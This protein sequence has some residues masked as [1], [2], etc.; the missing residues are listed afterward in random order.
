MHALFYRLIIR[1]NQTM[2]FRWRTITLYNTLAIMLV[3]GFMLAATFGMMIGMQTDEH[4]MMSGCPFMSEQAS[5]CPMGVMEHIAKWQQLVTAVLFTS[6]TSDSFI[7]FLLA[8]VIFFYF[9]AY[10]KSLFL[11]FVPSPPVMHSR[12]EIALY[13][14]L[15]IAF[16]QGI[17]H[18]RLYA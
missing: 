12:Q 13:H 3:G 18:P 7:F 6:H 17:L 11:L 14:H 9:C 8:V 10:A 1:Y 2:G 15:K 16:S 4:G 5:I